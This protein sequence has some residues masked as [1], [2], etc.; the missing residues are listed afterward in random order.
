MK[1]VYAFL[2]NIYKKANVKWQ[3]YVKYMLAL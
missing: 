1:I 3:G 2:E